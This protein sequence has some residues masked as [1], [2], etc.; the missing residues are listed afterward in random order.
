MAHKMHFSYINEAK[1]DEWEALVKVAPGGGFMQSFSWAGFKRRIGWQTYKIG[2]LENDV[3]IGG[4]IV[5]KFPFSK[6][7]NFLYI[8]EG[9]IMPYTRRDADELFH[10]LI[11]EIDAVADLK[12]PSYTT[13]LRIEP[14]LK[15]APHFFQRFQKA[16]YNLEPRDTLM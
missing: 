9:P 3:L 4:A 6:N 7:K 13:H 16:P 14:R 12:G 15:S 5:M 8:P 10:Q 2:L 1:K 11:G